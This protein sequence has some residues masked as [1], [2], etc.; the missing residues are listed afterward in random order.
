MKVNFSHHFLLSF[1]L[2]LLV[3]C[4]NEQGKSVASN[5]TKKRIAFT[6]ENK[7]LA[8]FEKYALKIDGNKSLSKIQ[9]LFY[10]ASDGNTTEAFAWIDENMEVL[11]LQQNENM[12]SGKKIER[13]FYF[14]N[15]LKTMSRQIT[16]HYELKKPYFSEQR[17]YYSLTGAVIATFSRYSSTEELDLIDLKKT[18]KQELNHQHALS[19]IKRTGDFE[20]RFRGFDEAFGR[21]FIVLGT[22]N[23]TSTL[24]FNVESPILKQ[25]ISAENKHKNERLEV[26]FSPITEPDGFTFQALVDLT[27]SSKE[28]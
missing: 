9:S 25:L 17:S 8:V 15:G 26:Q 22:E 19:I 21:K 12:A 6:E 18:D 7:N 24:A 5:S 3:S 16:Y 2:L 4:K 23:Q 20:T 10:T 27:Y 1:S 14:L 28:N 13:I 11:K